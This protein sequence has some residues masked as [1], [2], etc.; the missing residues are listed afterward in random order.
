M[1]VSDRFLPDRA[2]NSISQRY[3]RLCFLIYKSN[4]IFIDDEG[5]LAPLPTF[6]KGSLIAE[7]EAALRTQEAIAKIKPPAP[8]STMNVHRWTIEEDV[9]ILKAVPMMGNQWAEITHHI[10]PH[11][12]RGHIRKRYQVLERRIP[13]GTMRINIKRP[14]TGEL[15]RVATKY[16]KT[17]VM[18]KPQ[19]KPQPKPQPPKKKEP[20]KA[21]GNKSRAKPTKATTNLPVTSIQSNVTKMSSSYGVTIDEDDEKGAALL[22]KLSTPQRLRQENKHLSQEC[23]AARDLAYILNGQ[24]NSNTGGETTRMGLEKILENNWSQQSGMQRF[25]DA[26]LADE[27][28]PNYSPIKSN[29]L[30][31]VAAGDA[32]SSRLSMMNDFNAAEEDQHRRTSNQGARRSLLSSA[33]QKTVENA[34]KRKRTEAP[35]ERSVKVSGSPVKVNLGSYVS[36]PNQSPTSNNIFTEEPFSLAAAYGHL[37]P[38]I[39]RAPVKVDTPG[40]EGDKSQFNDEAFQYFM[41]GSPLK[42]MTPSKLLPPNTP[43]NQLGYTEG[44]LSGPAEAGNNSLWMAD[45]DFD[46][47][48]ALQDLSNSAPPTPSKLLLP[49]RISQTTAGEAAASLT[50]ELGQPPQPKTSFLSKVKAKVGE[51]QKKT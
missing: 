23:D 43:L 12:D 19:L 38:Q 51:S 39:V 13:K 29:H 25:L 28:K 1:L 45:D 10:L 14:A 7:D 36:S 2:V 6:K 32:D 4:G 41:S 49:S 50:E 44:V 8:P 40:V 20:R 21:N 33:M 47:V 27:S 11:R 37:T 35:P 42:S 5:K 30:S 31:N 17:A 24:D 22:H 26:K 15:G 9:A 3:H 34:S 18:P 46:C 16:A 48:S